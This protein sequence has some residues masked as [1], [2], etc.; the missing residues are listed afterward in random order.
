MH[1]GLLCDKCFLSRY[2]PS[3]L[4]QTL[5]LNFGDADWFGGLYPLAMSNSIL[6]FCVPYTLLETKKILT[7]FIGKTGRQPT[8]RMAGL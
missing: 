7:L 6:T 5:S 1:S 8:L 4:I 2:C 3:S